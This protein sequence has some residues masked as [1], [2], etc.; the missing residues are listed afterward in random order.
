MRLTRVYP[1]TL[2]ETLEAT[3]NHLVN[4]DAPDVVV[5]REWCVDVSNRILSIE[6][7]IEEMR[8]E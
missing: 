7:A 5:T 3:Y 4:P 8:G 6:V 1:K 2:E